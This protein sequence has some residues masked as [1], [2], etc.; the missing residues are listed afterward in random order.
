M[1]IWPRIEIGGDTLA[2]PGGIDSAQA[3]GKRNGSAGSSQGQRAGAFEQGLNR[4][5]ELCPELDL[6]GDR[7]LSNFRG[8]TGIEKQLVRYLHGLAHDINGSIL[9]PDRQAGSSLILVQIR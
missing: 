6:P 8:Q 1:G 9:L 7:P 3:F 2:A 4:P 5:A